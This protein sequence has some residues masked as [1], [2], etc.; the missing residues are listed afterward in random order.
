MSTE[1]TLYKREQKNTHTN[2]KE[3]IR[4]KKC[5]VEIRKAEK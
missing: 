4:N 1:I 2:K 3:Q 5:K